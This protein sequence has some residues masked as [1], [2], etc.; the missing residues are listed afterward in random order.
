M[1]SI[2]QLKIATILYLLVPSLLFLC[3]W[4]HLW[5]GIPCI[6]FMV[7]YVKNIFETAEDKTDNGIAT[8]HFFISIGISL[9]LNFMLGIGEFRYQTYDF[10]ANNFKFYDL[11]TH[12]LPV[13]YPKQ[14]TFLCYYT[15]YYLPSAMLAKVFGLASCRYIS[16][17]WSVL[18]LALVFLWI[19]T[20]SRKSFMAV[21]VGILL[22]SHSW[23]VIKVLMNIEFFKEVCQ[24]YYFQLNQ[25]KLITQSFVKNYS[26]AI[27]HTLPAC[28]GA[29]VLI[30]IY[31]RDDFK[32]ELKYLLLMLLSTMFWSPL[33]TIGLFPFV[34]F[35]FLQNLKMLFNSSEMKNLL[36]MIGIVVA[37]SPLML[38]FISTEGI[39]A[40][41][42][43]FMWETG[44]G[45]WF[46]IYLIYIFSNFIIWGV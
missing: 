38:Y 37:F 27:Q 23:I 44:V 30:H 11:V 39:H 31:Q 19:S 6:V 7:F 2:Q 18:G 5:I 14:Q 24:P 29:C 28:L 42:T 40:N 34:A 26:W 32:Q 43:E 13:Y 1:K 46:L 21:I 33:T 41:N 22:F 20:F 15:G 35:C 16:Y 17:L 10:Q 12:Q 36:W 4:V 9:L 25:F 8:Q 45:F 3:T